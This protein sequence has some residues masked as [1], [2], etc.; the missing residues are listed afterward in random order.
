VT[1]RPTRATVAG[2]AYLDLQN[3]AR[4]EGRP[5]DELHQIYALEGFLARLVVSPYVDRF[6]LKGGVLLAAYDTRRPT[7]DIDL[8]GQRLSNDVESVLDAVRTIAAV[9]VDD[10][11]VLD[12]DH[13]TADSIREADIYMGV[14]VSLTGELS[15]A[16]L[17]FHVDVN[18][19][20]PVWPPPQV[21]ALPRL[22]DGE[23][24]IAGYPLPMVH[25]EK[26][27]TAVQRGIANTRWRDFADVYVLARRHDLNGDE[28]SAAVKRVAQHRGVRLAPLQEVLT[29]YADLAQRRWATWRRKQRLDDRLPEQFGDVLDTVIGF[30]DPVMTDT[31]SAQVWSGADR[32]WRPGR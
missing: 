29:G 4:R 18:V 8:Q 25:A 9:P 10:G 24:A 31:V 3:L 7:R 15:A 19:G 22:L 17:A 11:L 28:L 6:V 13:A 2:R 27:V 32:M 21:V 1:E 14:R 16:R 26:L 20:D 12:P 5:T 23:I 30:A